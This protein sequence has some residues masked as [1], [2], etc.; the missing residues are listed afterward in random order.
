[1]SCATI[2]D[3]ANAI[4]GDLGSPTDLSVSAIQSKLTSDAFLGQLNLLV[5]GCHT[6]VSGEIV[7]AL[8]VQ[9]QAIYSLMYQASF[10]ARKLALLAT[11]R[12]LP[13]TLTE[14]DSKM[15]FASAVDLMRLYRD[16]QKQ[17]TDELNRL[18][19]AYVTNGLTPGDVKYFSVTL[20]G[21]GAFGYDMGYTQI[22][23]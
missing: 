8:D 18:A 7:P 4:W 16:M 13:V 2:T 9:E 17:L 10:Y 3:L 11:G 19:A 1:M 15:V 5:N 12:M 21:D 20:G 23:N 6:V 22:G 14:G